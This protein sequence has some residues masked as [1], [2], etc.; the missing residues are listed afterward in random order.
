M[1]V[2]SRAA[3]GAEQGVAEATEQIT[4]DAD[5]RG[6]TGKPR[7]GERNRDRIGRKRNAG[8]DIAA[9]PWKHDNPPTIVRAEK[10]AS[11]HSGL[12]SN[13]SCAAFRI[14]NRG[15]KRLTQSSH[16]RYT[17]YLPGQLAAVLQ[18]PG[19][20]RVTWRRLPRV[21]LWL[22]RR[23]GRL[24][25]NAERHFA[26][27]NNTRVVEHTAPDLRIAESDIG[28]F[29]AIIAS[30]TAISVSTALVQGSNVNPPL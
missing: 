16:Y 14:R 4:I 29:Q 1:S 22:S 8:D 10:T 15:V 25:A 27:G 24:N 26:R 17:D 23:R 20:G 12:C 5:L 6:E 30:E 9:Q 3:R 7:I 13:P 18:R 21:I 11:V 2:R 28:N 19:T